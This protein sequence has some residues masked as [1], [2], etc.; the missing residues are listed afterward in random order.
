MIAIFRL[1]CHNISTYTSEKMD[2]KNVS[3]FLTVTEW[4]Q[5]TDDLPLIGIMVRR[6][7]VESIHLYIQK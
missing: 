2:C 1:G 7:Y 5:R 4:L 6:Q 3:E